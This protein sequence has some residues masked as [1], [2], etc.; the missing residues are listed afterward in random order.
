[1]PK[2]VSPKRRAKKYARFIKK[3]AKKA[4]YFNWGLVHQFRDAMQRDA[5]AKGQPNEDR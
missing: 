1:M 5:P 4:A 3:A 2:Y